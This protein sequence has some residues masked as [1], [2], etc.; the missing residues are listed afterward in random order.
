MTDDE[1]MRMADLWAG[2]MTVKQI[3]QKMGYA[4]STV[5]WWALRRRDLFPARR[6]TF[7]QQERDEWADRFIGGELTAEECAR[8]AGCT[9]WTV[10]KWAKDRRAQ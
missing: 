10:Y 2:A 3:A 7:T 5:A 8:Q 6:R 9:A 4:E 1:L